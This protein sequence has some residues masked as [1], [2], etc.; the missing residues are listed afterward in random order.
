MT[1][2]DDKR[3]VVPDGQKEIRGLTST[4]NVM[5][6]MEN[7][8]EEIIKMVK[9]DTNVVEDLLEQF[10][11]QLKLYRECYDRRSVRICTMILK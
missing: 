9:Q 11:F 6:Q 5:A 3:A 2:I 1:V 4:H 7:K 10:E 8:V